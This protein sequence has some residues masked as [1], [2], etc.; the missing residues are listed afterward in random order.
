MAAVDVEQSAV[1]PSAAPD[2]AAIR[3]DALCPLCDYD[4]RGLVEPRCPECGYRFEWPMVLDPEHRVHPYLFEHH[5]RRNVRSFVR[6]LL[7]GLRPR[8]FW[9]ALRPTQPS[10]PGRLVVYWLLAN[11]LLPVGV[12]VLLLS[13]ALA[14]APEQARRRAAAM[15]EYRWLMSQVGRGGTSSGYA[16][17]LVA[18][19]IGPDAYADAQ[20]A[21]PVSIAYLRQIYRDRFDRMAADSVATA[22]AYL[23]WPWLTFATLMIF[24]ASMRRAKVKS[25]H[26]L[27]CVLYGCDA[28]LWAGL[29]VAL[30]VPPAL[31]WLFPAFPLRFKFVM[32]A[33]AIF[34]AFTAYRLAA[35]YRLY[36]RFDHPAAT[37]IASQTVVLLAAM[38]LLVG[39]SRFW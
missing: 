37:A 38:V 12:V 26:V 39:F 35:A 28:G 16:A 33:S 4:L 11:L 32:A 21:R 14:N 23:L 30:L 17:S 24:Q 19:G 27:R 8:R 20:Y 2:W 31:A 15:S 29:L 6:T 1:A 18:R 5:P 7:A 36:L 22:V 9:A 34:A 3:E 13:T 10:R 25:S